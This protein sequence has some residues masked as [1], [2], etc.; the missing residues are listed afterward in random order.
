MSRQTLFQYCPKFILFSADKKNVLLAQR[1]G[2]QDYDGTFSFIGGKTETTDESLL[3]GLKREK[4]EEIGE[5]A[6]VKICWT[7]SCYQVLFRKKDGNAMIIP[8][9]IGLFVSGDIVLNSTEYADYK[10]VPIAEL[11]NFKPMIENIPDAVRA[12]QRFLDVL[13]EA[14]FEEI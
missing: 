13:S 2:E 3:D 4:N 1:K 8:H 7:M 6:R 5:K 11:A 10:W 14:D 12:A 9:H